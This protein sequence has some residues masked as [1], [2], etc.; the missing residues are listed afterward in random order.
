ME[1]HEPA[2]VSHLLA[3]AS[4]GPAMVSHEPAMVSHLPAM[5]SHEPASHEPRHSVVPISARYSEGPLCSLKGSF[6]L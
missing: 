2:M 4:H 3:M 5:A 6:Q 1:S